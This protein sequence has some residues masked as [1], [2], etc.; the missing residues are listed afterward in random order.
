MKVRFT[1]PALSDLEEIH[2]YIAQDNRRAAS[3]LVQRLV[4]RAMLIGSAP[5]QGREVDE[6]DIRVVMV[7]R[8]RLLHLLQN[9]PGRDRDRSHPSYFPPPSLAGAVAALP[10]A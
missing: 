10:S 1:R 2:S 8:F 6:P 3:R 9:Q 4:D 7:P 5:H